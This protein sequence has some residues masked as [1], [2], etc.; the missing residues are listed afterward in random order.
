MEPEADQEVRGEPHTFP[1]EEELDEIVGCD[2]HQ[3]REGKQRQ[4]GEE[5]RSV[6][7]LFHIAPAI[8]VHEARNAR[9][10]GH[11]DDRHGVDT[12]RPVGLKTTNVHPGHKLDDVLPDIGRGA[13]RISGEGSMF[14]VAMPAR[15]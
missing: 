3:H 8:Q 11:H 1:A 2:Q 12:D 4:I 6:R 13:A 9:N 15:A 10:H 14:N 5:A 7:V